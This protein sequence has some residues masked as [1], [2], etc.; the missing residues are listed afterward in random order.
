MASVKEILEYYS[1]L[2][3]KP[4]DLIEEL[5]RDIDFYIF[6]ATGLKFNQS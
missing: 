1:T 2:E 5:K 3:E 6:L 4:E